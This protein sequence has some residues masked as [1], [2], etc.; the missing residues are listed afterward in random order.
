MPVGVEQREVM[1]A[2]GTHEGV[3]FRRTER[4]TSADGRLHGRCAH[5]HRTTFYSRHRTGGRFS[6]GHESSGATPDS[7]IVSKICLAETEAA[8]PVAGKKKP[9][10]RLVTVRGAGAENPIGSV[11]RVG[12]APARTVFFVEGAGVGVFD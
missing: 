1:P 2:N 11:Y 7:E 8:G 5:R 3:S 12:P 4:G 9:P 6:F 10:T